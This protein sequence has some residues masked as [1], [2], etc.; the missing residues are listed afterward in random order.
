MKYTKDWDKEWHIEKDDYK[1]SN[2]II[3]IFESYLDELSKKNVSKKT[4]KRH[5]VACFSLGNHIIGI[6]FGYQTDSFKHN[7]T[8]ENI[9]L[10]YIDKYEGPLVHHDNESW[11]RELDTTCKKLYKHIKHRIR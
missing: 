4:F 8:G 11:Q 5:E 2:K 10:Y 9:L 6:I 1:I 3:P 7:E